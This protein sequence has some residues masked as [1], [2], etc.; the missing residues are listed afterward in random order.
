MTE[1]K[2]QKSFNLKQLAVIDEAISIS[3]DVVH[4]S[5]G[6]TLSD[7]KKNRYDIRTLKNLR[8]PEITQNVFAQ[9][10]R[11]SR[12][13]PPLGEREGDFYSICIQ[14]HNILEA[15]SKRKKLSLLPFLVYIV[16]HELIHITRFYMFQQTFEANPRSHE[17]EEAR[18]HQL[19]FDFLNIKKLK[20]MPIILDFFGDHRAL[21]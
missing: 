6:L 1:D 16:T 21:V 20:G 12:R 7:W 11:Y 8:A 3:E 19:T 9:I 17:I 4:D 10:M 13:L 14:D 2:K 18:V 15:I 5:Y